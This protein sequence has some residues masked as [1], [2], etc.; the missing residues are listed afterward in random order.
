MSQIIDNQINIVNLRINNLINE[1]NSAQAL[2]TNLQTVKNQETS[3]ENLF[4]FDKQ[5]FLDKYDFDCDGIVSIIDLNVISLH[6]LG[7]LINDPLYNSENVTYNG[8]SL[9]INND[10]EADVADAIAFVNLIIKDCFNLN[11]FVDVNIKFKQ[12]NSDLAAEIIKQFYS[13]NH[14]LPT[15]EEFNTEYNN[16]NNNS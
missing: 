12:S 5:A 15:L 4:V 11:S 2:L 14:R 7:Y 1:L 10:N 6:V 9:D 8:K 13:T 16:Q 3:Y